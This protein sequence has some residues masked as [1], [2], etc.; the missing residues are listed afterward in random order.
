MIANGEGSGGGGA[1]RVEDVE[2]AVAGHDVK[3]LHQVTLRG[4]GLGADSGAPGGEIRGAQ[5]GHEALEGA[6]E[7]FLAEAFGEAGE[8][9]GTMA[10]EKTPEAGKEEGVGEVAEVDIMQA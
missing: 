1:G 4:H 5:F 3:I 6:A 10:E 2:C 7:A 9:H 8:G